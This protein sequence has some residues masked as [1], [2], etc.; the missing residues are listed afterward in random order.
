M[1][2]HSWRTILSFQDYLEYQLSFK[3]LNAFQLVFV[4]QKI[5]HR[6][7]ASDSLRWGN[8]QT[9][10]NWRTKLKWCQETWALR[11]PTPSNKIVLE[12]L[13]SVVKKLKKKICL[14]NKTYRIGDKTKGEPQNGCEV[15]FFC[16]KVI[17]TNWVLYIYWMW[18]PWF[19]G[20]YNLHTTIFF[21]L[22]ESYHF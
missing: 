8:E 21:R 1:F 19:D 11:G 16:V 18:N 10:F 3:V 15:R 4:H 6:S 7:V 12:I 14:E 22:L 5:F 13:K 2:S 17:S 9:C 20:S